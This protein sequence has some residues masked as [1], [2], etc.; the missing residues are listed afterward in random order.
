MEGTESA[1]SVLMLPWL[2]HGHIS[3]FLELAKRLADR[4][5][6]AYICSTPINFQSIKKKITQKYANSIELVPFH[7]P[8]S[9]ELPPHY[10][11]TNGLPPHLMCTLKNEYEKASPQ[12]STILSQLQ[13]DLVIYDFNQPWAAEMAA[14]Q[15]IPAVN[16]VTGAAS[17]LAF[18]W[19]MINNPQ[20]EFPCPEICLRGYEIERFRS[21]GRSLGPEM[22]KD[23]DRFL[24]ALRSSCSILL[25]KSCRE[26]EDKYIDLLSNLWEKKAVPVGQLVEDCF[27][28]ADDDHFEIIQFL[29]KKEEAS[30]IFVSFGSEYFLTQEERNVI[31]KGLE[32]SAVD[33]IWVIRFPAGEKIAIEEA[34]PEGF[35]ER[36]KDRGM[37]VEGWAPQA[38][39][40]KHSSTG[41]FLSHCGW[42]SVMESM[43]FGVP[44]VAMPMHIDQPLNARLVEAVGV[45]VEAVRDEEGKLQSLE[46]AKAVRQVVVEESGEEVRK[47]V[48]QLSQKLQIKGDEEIDNLV[49]EMRKL[50]KKLR[51]QSATV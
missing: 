49:V 36:I 17:V 32:E 19:F 20:A 30:V 25:V 1:A 48:K 10:H 27:S 37:V 38:R 39:I 33:F 44:I 35:L 31:A 28:D 41:G 46:I 51:K 29:D 24:G 47:K 15:N 50:C 14:S 3:P 23:L 43:K 7:I 40:L 18:S 45:G 11:T 6:H 2:A 22:Q 21:L 16:F 12:F 5:F 9:P 8:P 26:I 4:N 34:L 13:P 42:S